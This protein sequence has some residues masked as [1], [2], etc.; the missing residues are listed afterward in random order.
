MGLQ[1]RVIA[2]TTATVL[3]ASFGI[4][5]LVV[6]EEINPSGWPIPSLVG[7]RSKK[8]YQKDAIS[9]VPGKETSVTVRQSAD[10]Q[11]FATF[12]CNGI[13]YAYLVDTDGV[14][15]FDYTLVDRNSDGIFESKYGKDERIHNPDY[16][17]L[18]IIE[19]IK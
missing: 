13:I 8:P 9:Q 16:M 18:V 15:P 5:R 14:T 19:K 3:T 10:G 17:K 6:A 7:A 11:F 2:L 1:S 4:A 12:E